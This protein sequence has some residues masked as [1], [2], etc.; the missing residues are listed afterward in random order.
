MIFYNHRKKTGLVTFLGGCAIFVGLSAIIAV[1]TLAGTSLF[2]EYPIES[3]FLLFMTGIFIYPLFKKKGKVYKD[4]IQVK[5]EHLIIDG[6]NVPL[7]KINVDT[8]Q[9]DSDFFRYHIWDTSN[10]FSLYSVIKDDLFNH[11]K[12]STVNQANF[13]VFKSES[14]NEN[15]NII[16]EKRI[17]SYNLETGAYK[18]TKE[19]NI[20]KNVTPTVFCFDGKFSLNR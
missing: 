13:E 10:T 19:T 15:I 20:V 3:I 8:Y 4:N 9:I 18:I 12:T 6:I 16:T 11:L 2:S 5:K 14:H 1:F 7:S 17:L